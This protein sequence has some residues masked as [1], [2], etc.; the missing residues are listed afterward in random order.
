M[1]V[2]ADL[3]QRVP[4]RLALK[5]AEL[6]DAAALHRRPRPDLAD[7]A[8]QSGMTVTARNVRRSTTG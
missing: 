5:I 2:V 4:W 8:P 7:G 6:V 1:E 3:S